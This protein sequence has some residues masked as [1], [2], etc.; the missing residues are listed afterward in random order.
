MQNGTGKYVANAGDHTDTTT[1]DNAVIH[2]GIYSNDQSEIIRLIGNMFGRITEWCRASE[3]FETNN[4]VEF[5]PKIK[6][7]I[8]FGFETVNKGCY[9]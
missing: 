4:M 7:E 6:E 8:G 5:F 2:L 9:K 1:S 3:F